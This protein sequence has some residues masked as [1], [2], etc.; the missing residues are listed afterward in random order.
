[1]IYD[2]SVKVPNIDSP[3][4]HLIKLNIGSKESTLWGSV[5]KPSS[6]VNVQAYM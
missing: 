5:W 2:R 1:M 3:C 4:H 6:T